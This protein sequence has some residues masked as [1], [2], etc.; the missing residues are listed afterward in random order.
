M[1][2]RTVVTTL[3]VLISPALI[4]AEENPFKDAKKGEW[5]AYKMVMKFG[6]QE[7]TGNVKQT[8]VD[9]TN[10]E[11][12]IE[13]KANIFGQEQT[14]KHTVD[15]TK[16]Y[17]PLSTTQLPPG[18]DVKVEKGETGKEKLEI[19]GTK[20]DTEWTRFKMKM[21]IMGQDIDGEAKVWQSKKIPLGGVA[22]MVMKMNFMGM[23]MEMAMELEKAGQDN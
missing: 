4:W 9:K 22:K 15:L 2:L 10:K 16:P 13:A 3:A 20:Y 11:V 17:D 5:A 18:A 8:V 19:G 21:N 1:L 14:Q 23:E 7:I 6:G 12:T